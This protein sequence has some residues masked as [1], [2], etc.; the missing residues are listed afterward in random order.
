MKKILF[1]LPSLAPAGG[2]E[3]VTSTLM[4]KLAKYYDITVLTKDSRAS[5]YSLHT[6][7]KHI[8]LEAHVGLNMKNRLSRAFALGLNLLKTIIKLKKTSLNNFDYIY[9]TH[10]LSHIELLLSNAKYSKIVISEHGASNNYNHIYRIIK[11]ITYKYCHAYCIPTKNDV[12]YYSRE[13]FPVKYTPHYMPDLNYQPSPLNKKTILNIGRYTDDKKQLTLLKIW[14]DISDKDKSGWHL[15]I[16][17][18]GELKD[19]LQQYIVEN[20]LTT[21]VTLLPPLKNVEKYYMNSSIFALTSRSEGF[22]MVLL[23]ATGFGLPLVSFDCP[24]G[25]RDII[26]DTNGFLIKMDDIHT[27]KMTLIRL[28]NN[29]NLLHE[30]S[31]GSL[32]TAKFWSDDN[33]T[34]I[35]R[36]IFS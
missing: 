15:N 35:W 32:C 31:S 8:S 11:K 18:D 21:S 20:N 9:I 16:V 12:I 25:P 17:G 3:R 7:I 13:N 33:I 36:D 2:I 14:N 19:I 5:F 24:S 10:P 26:S 4:N 30:L 23:E 1:Y 6:N 22:G 34:K 28:M 29:N 27:Y